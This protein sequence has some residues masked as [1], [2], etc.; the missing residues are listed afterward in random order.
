MRPLS[1]R[2]GRSPQRRPV[3]AVDAGPRQTRAS[4][5]RERCCEYV[6]KTGISVG[7]LYPV[8]RNGFIVARWC[9]LGGSSSLAG[10]L[11]PLLWQQCRWAIA[12]VA[13]NHILSAVRVVPRLGAHQ[14]A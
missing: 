14:S 10:G 11:L 2:V 3:M 13:K 6:R 9:P 7:Q 5:T 8:R 1:R 4:T 12:K